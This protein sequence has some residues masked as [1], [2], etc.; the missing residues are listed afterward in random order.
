MTP[1]RSEEALTAD[2]ISLTLPAEDEFQGVAH[3]VL[4]G[5]AVRLDL[6]FETL[7]D[8]ELG[9]DAVLGRM[10]TGG[11]VTV[12]LRVQPGEF[13]TRVGPIGD[14]LREQIEGPA[15]EELGLRRILDT[16]ADRVEFSADG[17]WV[18]LAKRV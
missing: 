8:L 3:L 6:T 12:A 17:R 7:E 18:E 9:L 4:G 16:V 14:G 13:V 2:E 5:L 15:K 11:D 1:A 10:Q